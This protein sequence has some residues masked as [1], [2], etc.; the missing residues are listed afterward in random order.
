MTAHDVPVARSW[1][2]IDRP[3]NS[4]ASRLFFSMSA[5]SK[6]LELRRSE[7][8]QAGPNRLSRSASGCENAAVGDLRQFVDPFGVACLGIDGFD[9]TVITFVFGSRIRREWREPGSSRHSAAA[10]YGSGLEL[11]LAL[12]ECGGRLF[13][14]RNIEQPG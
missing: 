1:A 11:L 6:F 5:H 7:P 12:R 10:V 9:G 8:G 2:V 13:P 3:Y 4:D 14:G